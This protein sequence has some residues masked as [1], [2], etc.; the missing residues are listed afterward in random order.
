MESCFS[1]SQIHGLYYSAS[2]WPQALQPSE[3]DAFIEHQAGK[4]ILIVLHLYFIRWPHIRGN[5]FQEGLASMKC[6]GHGGTQMTCVRTSG[7]FA[8]Q[9]CQVLQGSTSSLR[10]SEEGEYEHRRYPY[11][12]A[13]PYTHRLIAGH[14]AATV[15][16][17]LLYYRTTIPSSWNF[18]FEALLPLLATLARAPTD[19]HEQLPQNG[20]EKWTV[21]SFT[22]IV[23]LVTL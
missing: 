15:P 8:C 7:S 9:N 16:H 1:C 17:C 11:Y 18:R 12:P 21:S 14:I 10:N 4:F 13:E 22:M 20:S 19:D 5:L 6:Q 3:L 2:E 23:S